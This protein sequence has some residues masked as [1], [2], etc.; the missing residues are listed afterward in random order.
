MSLSRN[1]I[2]SSPSSPPLPPPPPTLHERARITRACER[3]RSRK[4]RCDGQ[5][6]CAGCRPRNFP[7]IYR[8]ATRPSR[9]R[10]LLD[11]RSAISLRFS[12]DPVQFKRHRELRAGIG[13]S[14]VDTGSFQFYGPSSH[15]CFIQRMC[16]RIARSPN[17]TILTPSD[18][19]PDGVRKWNLERFMFC[20]NGCQDSTGPHAAYISQE[21]GMGLIDSYFEILHPQIPVLNYSEIV[22]QWKSLWKPPAQQKPDKRNE[23]LFI[24]LAIGARV[25]IAAGQQETSLLEGWAD[26]FAAQANRSTAVLEDPSLSSTQL[27][28]LKA[29]YAYQVM[30]PNDAY[31]YLGHAARNAMVLGFNRFQVMDGTN[32]TVHALKRTF[33]TV[34]AHERM[35]ALYAGRPSAFRDEMIDAPYPEDLPLPAMTDTSTDSSDDQYDPIRLCGFIRA[36]AGVARVADL[37]F[38]KIYSPASVASMAQIALLPAAV[39]E[40]DGLLGAVTRDL[41]LYLQFFDAALPIGSGW[42][43]VQRLTL[44][45]NYY[46]TQMLTHR[47]ALLFRAFFPSLDEA[48]RRTGH[49][50]ELEHSIQ[51]ALAAA[52]NIINLTHDVY[53]RRCPRA[54]FDGS[55]ATIMVA[56]AVTLLY[57]VLDPTTGAE[58]AREVFATVERAVECLDQIEHVGPTSGKAEAL[59]MTTTDVEVNQDFIGTFPWLQ[60]N[61]LVP[62]NSAALPYEAPRSDPGAIPVSTQGQGILSSAPDTAPPQD[63]ALHIPATMPNYM[64]YWLEA[65]FSP[66]NIPS[67]LF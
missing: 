58:H 65:G 52:T 60:Y 45:S 36:M 21:V 38:V 8:S 7:C 15:F 55:S 28:L 4:V 51:E 66:E 59:R 50:L 63:P 14:N 44:G 40:I 67:S 49:T 47:P 20:V 26:H 46:Q 6:P 42:Q 13:V 12:N 34:Y 29:M 24:V 16:Q 18:T 1:A 61:L 30:R 62:P 5:T 11:G 22:D 41:P 39:A 48:Q 23:V 19:V 54:R 64:S 35:N 9:R 27:L 57:D 37:M 32:V 25:T 3:C 2:S 33:W 43:E 56:A 31:L 17:E 10:K 53:F